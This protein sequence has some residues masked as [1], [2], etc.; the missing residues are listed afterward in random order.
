MTIAGQQADKLG[1]NEQLFP[2]DFNFLQQRFADGRGIDGCASC[3]YLNKASVV[4]TMFSISELACASSKGM[5]L[6]STLWLG[7]NVPACF[8]AASAARASIHDFRTCLRKVLRLNSAMGLLIHGGQTLFHF[9]W[10]TVIR[11]PLI[12]ATTPLRIGI[13]RLPGN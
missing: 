3:A 9:A 10:M 13:S 2:A 12:N 8:R 11:L 6:I 7:I 4:V 1:M 5:V